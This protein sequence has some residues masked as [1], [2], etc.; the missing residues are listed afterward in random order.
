[1]GVDAGAELRHP[2]RLHRQA[3]RLPV[4]AEPQEQVG[5]AL[6]R[7]EHVEGRDAAARA[8]R[9]VAVDRQHD[10]RL[11]VGVHQLRRD[12]ADDAAVP[13]VAADD[14]HVVRAD[15]RVGLDRL[16]R[17]GDELGFLRLPPQVLVV[18]LLRQAARFVDHGFVVA[19]SSSRV[20]MSGVLMRPAALSAAPA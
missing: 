2:R 1:M 19:R 10:R 8:V 9:D 4:A 5:A 7:A 14:E 6:E 12:D 17:L 20:A 13:A 16:A 11:V 18:Q 3:G 15:R